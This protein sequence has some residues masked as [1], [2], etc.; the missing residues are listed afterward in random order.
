MV[1]VS[2][3]ELASRPGHPPSGGELTHLPSRGRGDRQDEPVAS[4]CLVHE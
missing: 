1:S 4:G 3:E 2:P